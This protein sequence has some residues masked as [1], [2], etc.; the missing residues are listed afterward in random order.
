MK[1]GNIYVIQN[2]SGNFMTINKTFQNCQRGKHKKKK[3]PGH[4]YIFKQIVIVLNLYFNFMFRQFPSYQYLVIP[5]Y[6]G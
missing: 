6:I 1:F 3:K 5:D 2:A 4:C